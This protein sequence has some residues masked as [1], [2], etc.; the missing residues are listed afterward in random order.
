[1]TA[2]DY[3]ICL[4]V[5]IGIPVRL[6]LCFDFFYIITDRVLTKSF[7]SVKMPGLKNYSDFFFSKHLP[8]HNCT[9][10]NDCHRSHITDYM[11]N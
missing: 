4:H 10:N 3:E 7:L 6:Q 8:L 2:I 11:V 1:M 9:D 5:M